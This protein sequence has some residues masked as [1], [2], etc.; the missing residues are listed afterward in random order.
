MVFYLGQVPRKAS[1]SGGNPNLSADCICSL[2]RIFRF[3]SFKEIESG[4]GFLSAYASSTPEGLKLAI[5]YQ[6][7][8]PDRINRLQVIATVSGS[9]GWGPNTRTLP[10]SGKRT[11]FKDTS[12]HSLH[13]NGRSFQFCFMSARKVFTAFFPIHYTSYRASS[14]SWRISHLLLPRKYDFDF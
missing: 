1:L 9:S 14:P 3:F 12:S 2:R 8:Q 4:F 7:S 10:D 6:I 5:A 13:I 11:F